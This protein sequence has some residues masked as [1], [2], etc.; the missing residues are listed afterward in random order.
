MLAAM[1]LVLVVPI[2]AVPCIVLFS[3]IQLVPDLVVAALPMLLVAILLTIGGVSSI[4]RP[5]WLTLM[6]A[7]GLWAAAVGSGGKPSRKYLCGAVF[8]TLGYAL[9]VEV[10][11]RRLERQSG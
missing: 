8:A 11:G 6:A 2:V 7:F 9:R 5:A 10:E 4:K 1:R 3:D